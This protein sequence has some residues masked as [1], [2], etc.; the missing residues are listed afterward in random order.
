ML[1]QVLTKILEQRYSMKYFSI[2]QMPCIVTLS[3]FGKYRPLH[4]PYPLAILLL[5]SPFSA[6]TVKKIFLRIYVK[7]DPGRKEKI[8]K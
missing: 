8:S 2:L 3:A 1:K 5:F 7:F 4:S 6:D